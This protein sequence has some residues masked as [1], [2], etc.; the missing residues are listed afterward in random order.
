MYLNSYATEAR[1]VKV[2][3]VNEITGVTTAEKIKEVNLPS[4]SGHKQYGEAYSYSGQ[5][6]PELWLQIGKKQIKQR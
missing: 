1:S 5:Y 2:E 3:D 4:Y 6:T